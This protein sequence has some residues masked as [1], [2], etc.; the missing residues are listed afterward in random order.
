MQLPAGFIAGLEAV[1]NRYL[2][3]DPDTGARMV[4]LSGHCIGIDLQ[5]L[6]LQLFIHPGQ[7][8]IQ[9]S[10]HIDAEPDTVLHGTPLGMARLGLGQSTEKTL[11]SG[12]VNITGDVETGQAFKA[13]LDAMDIDWGRLQLEQSTLAQHARI[14]E[15]AHRELDMVMP[16]RPQLIRIGP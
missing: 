16:Q 12:A 1:I 5:G 9:L 6:D 3:L 4:A 14:E 11:F 8:G 13:V 2:R 15:A 10:D 7:H